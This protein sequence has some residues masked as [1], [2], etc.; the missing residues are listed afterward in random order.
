MLCVYDMAEARCDEVDE[1]GD[2][3]V[4]LPPVPQPAAWPA[5]RLQT[6]DFRVETR[7][8]LPPCGLPH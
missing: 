3:R 2:L 8:V 7:V 5:P 6:R 4:E 1:V